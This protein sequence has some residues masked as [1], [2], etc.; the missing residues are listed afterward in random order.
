MT[1]P[2]KPIATFFVATVL[3]VT[4]FAAENEFVE[5][6]GQAPLSFL[7]YIQKL[8]TACFCNDSFKEKF[9]SE[10]ATSWIEL[11]SEPFAADLQS[12]RTLALWHL[13]DAQL[14]QAKKL[15]NA[16]PDDDKF[17]VFLCCGRLR[18]RLKNPF[19]LKTQIISADYHFEAILFSIETDIATRIKKLY[20]WGYENHVKRWMT[21]LQNLVKELEQSKKSS[22][23]TL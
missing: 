17:Y 22:V 9:L 16:L 10:K 1:Y 21:E 2:K 19:L 15:F 13:C 6:E 4:L 8:P 7:E 23:E 5:K 3:S 20:A 12:G 14:E 18:E 11:D